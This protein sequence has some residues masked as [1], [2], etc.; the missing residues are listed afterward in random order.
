[1]RV[2]GLRA[3]ASKC[4]HAELDGMTALDTGDPAELANV[5]HPMRQRFPQQTV[6]GACGGTD[7]THVTAIPEAGVAD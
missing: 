3:S 2:R 7:L 1:M 5:H 6:L 4:G